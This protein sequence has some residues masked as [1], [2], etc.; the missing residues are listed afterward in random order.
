MKTLSTDGAANIQ[1]EEDEDSLMDQEEVDLFI[2]HHLRSRLQ[3]HLEALMLMA[4]E[5][6]ILM[7]LD[8]DHCMWHEATYWRKFIPGLP[9]VGGVVSNVRAISVSKSFTANEVTVHSLLPPPVSPHLPPPAREI[10][11][12]LLSVGCH[13][14]PNGEGRV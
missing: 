6:Q 1:G 2:K 8:S 3:D 5:K 12:V 9:G 14:C 11:V 13:L 4:M 10:S 7:N